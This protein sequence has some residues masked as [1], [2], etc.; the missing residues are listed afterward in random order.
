MGLPPASADMPERVLCPRGVAHAKT[1]CRRLA[2]TDVDIRGPELNPLTLRF[3][4]KEAEYKYLAANSEELA[5]K[6]GLCAIVCFFIDVIVLVR[7][8]MNEASMYANEEAKSEH[9]T[10]QVVIIIFLALIG[11]CLL[12][13]GFTARL[14]LSRQKFS[15]GAFEQGAALL[16]CLAAITP[17]LVS[18]Y[19]IVRIAGIDPPTVLSST[20]LHDTGL[21]LA[22]DLVVTASHLLLPIRWSK[23][24]P[25]EVLGIICYV[26]VVIFVGSP[27]QEQARANCYMLVGLVALATVGKRAMEYADRN[28]FITMRRNFTEN[29]KAVEQPPTV[30]KFPLAYVVVSPNGQQA[31]GGRYMLVPNELPNGQP[32]WKKPGKDKKDDKFLYSSISGTWNMGGRKAEERRFCCDYAHITSEK[33]HGGAMPHQV[34]NWQWT[35]GS[36]FYKD[37]GITVSAAPTDVDSESTAASVSQ[38]SSLRKGITP[39]QAFRSPAGSLRDWMKASPMTTPTPVIMGAPLSMDPC[40]KQRDVLCVHAVAPAAGAVGETAYIS[41]DHGLQ[42]PHRS[43]PASPRPRSGS[44]QPSS[45][46]SGTFFVPPANS[47]PGHHRT[48][49]RTRARERDGRDRDC[50]RARDR[51]FRCSSRP[52]SSRDSRCHSRCPS[53]DSIS[54][55]ECVSTGTCD[56]ITHPSGFTGRQFAPAPAAKR[57]P[58]PERPQM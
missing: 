58:P 54:L 50:A 28:A 47:P 34:K 21:C 33:A 18:P 11:A 56:G 23:L 46:P 39:P 52:D 5:S 51:D 14:Q 44:S 15:P 45:P 10:V 20:Y 36:R 13:V 17:L 43:P 55:E 1:V 29:E 27:E 19:Y 24:W 12:A 48:Y 57:R 8:S 37:S 6:L 35:D 40:G 16:V 31:C 26:L 30:E 25:V 7:L 22:T 53:R 42:K 38:T 32:L 41:P 9:P 4:D 2:G 3:S 49:S